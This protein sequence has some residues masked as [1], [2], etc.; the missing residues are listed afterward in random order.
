MMRMRG[1]TARSRLG[2]D[3]APV[4][5]IEASLQVLDRRKQTMNWDGSWA[6][7]GSLVAF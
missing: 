4:L 3:M 6:S 2:A 7:Y 1:A 5:H